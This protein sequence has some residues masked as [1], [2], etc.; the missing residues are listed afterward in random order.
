MVSA[1]V[2]QSSMMSG[3]ADDATKRVTRQSV[4][5]ASAAAEKTNETFE[6]FVRKS[7]ISMGIKMDSILAGQVALEE[8]CTY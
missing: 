3:A 6:D 1:P 5:E 4:S 2:G 8:R 7:L